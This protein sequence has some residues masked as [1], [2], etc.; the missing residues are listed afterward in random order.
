MPSAGGSAG[1]YGPLIVTPDMVPPDPAHWDAQEQ[2]YRAGA[3]AWNGIYQQIVQDNA[4]FRDAAD[5]TGFDKAHE[6][7]ALLAE[8][9]K[10]ISEWHDGVATKCNGIAVVLRET[11]AAQDQ[12]VRDA[13]AKIQSAKLPGEREALVTQYHMQART[14]TGWGV[15]AA[16]ALHTSFK[17]S[18]ENTRALDLLTRYGDVPN[19]PAI[20]PVDNTSPGIEQDSDPKKKPTDDGSDRAPTA[21]PPKD[22]TGAASTQSG[23]EPGIKAA[24]GGNEGIRAAAGDGI[25]TATGPVTQATPAATSPRA[26]ASPLSGGSMPSMGGMG[27]GGGGAAGI[28]PPTR[29]SSV[30]APHSH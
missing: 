6:A 3:Q 21:E 18:T 17:G 5:S 26:A 1:S 7:G 16:M 22:V 30:R 9:A 4:A 13:D 28:P 23:V 8:E 11:G 12:L 15:E 24:T 25:S 10:T 29:G 27:S 2:T 19:S 14:Q 20:Q